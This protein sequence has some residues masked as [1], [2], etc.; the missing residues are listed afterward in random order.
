MRQTNRAVF[1]DFNA[2]VPAKPLVRETVTQIMNAPCNASAVHKFGRTARMQ[3]EDARRKVAE[4]LNTPPETIIFTSGAPEANNTVFMNYFDLPI[5]VSAIEHPTVARAVPDDIQLPLPVDNNGLL[6]L[7]VLEAR[8][9]E[10]EAPALISVIWVHN[11]TGVIQ[12]MDKI[13]DLAKKYGA[14]L[15]TD[16]SQAFGKVEIDILKHGFDMVTVSSH[17]IGGPQGVGALIVKDGLEFAPFIVGGGQEKFRRAGTE[18]VAGIAGF[19]VAAEL[20]VKEMSEYRKLAD[21]R[22][23]IQNAILDHA[24]N[25]VIFSKDVER[26]SNTLM[27]AVPDMNADATVIALD[28]EGIAVSSGSAC[29]SGKV[30]PSRSLQAMGVSEELAKCS[31]RVSL[32]WSTKPEDAD[33]FIDSWKKIYDRVTSKEKQEA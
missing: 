2:T 24:S 15:H 6:D 19:G 20:A 16:A 11:E 7:D 23:K 27:F 4:A 26:S 29:S 22:D 17:K 32:G 10:V 21:L 25:A 28:L 14:I 1:L 3:V 12:P 9:Q 33:A 5:L 31:I 13:A 18:N 8:L 30:S